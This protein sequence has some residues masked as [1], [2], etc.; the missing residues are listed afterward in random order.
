MP[1][2]SQSQREER[3]GSSS[4]AKRERR[5]NKAL[6]VLDIEPAR[7]SLAEFEL[8]RSRRLVK[9]TSH[10]VSSAQL[11]YELELAHYAR[12]PQQKKHTYIYIY[13]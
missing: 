12:E 11:V 3:R 5:Q 2:A 10:G 1:C 4:K 9:I 8:A 7:L 13:I 6:L